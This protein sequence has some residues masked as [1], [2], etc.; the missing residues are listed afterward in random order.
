MVGYQA[1]WVKN[2]E[3]IRLLQ[4]VMAMLS[5]LR[6]SRSATRLRLC[7]IIINPLQLQNNQQKPAFCANTSLVKAITLNAGCRLEAQ[8]FDFIEHCCKIIILPV[9]W[10][11]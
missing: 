3:G 1:L 2:D 11:G 9:D 5:G 6:A 8:Q 4:R 10:R 7:F